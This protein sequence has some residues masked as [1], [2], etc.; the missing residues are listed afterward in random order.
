MIEYKYKTVDGFNLSVCNF[1]KENPKGVVQIV[2]GLKEH[3]RRY[4]RF[5]EYLNSKGYG[6]FLSDNRGHGYSVDKNNPLGF[7]SGIDQL[8]SDQ[9]EINCHIKEQY[10]RVP[11]YML[12]HS[13][14]S[15]IARKYIQKNDETINGLILSGTVGFNSG[16]YFGLIISRLMNLLL[17]RKNYSRILWQI[18]DNGDVSWVCGN[19]EIMAEY[20]SDPF[21]IG[22]KYRNN[23]VHT[24][25]EAMRELHNIKSYDCKNPVLPILS[26]AGEKDPVTRFDAGIKDSML[27]LKKAGYMNIKSIVYE[28]MLHE[29]LN[30]KE[31]IKV[32]EDVIKFLEGI[33]YKNN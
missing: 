25:M 22:Y 13:F 1:F 2:H 17:G 11:V 5:A 9:Y 31:N 32:Y 20:N 23:A 21:C 3:K 8:V 15:M 7:M 30:E 24:I 19:E 4:Y 27:S 14:G 28:N 16:V 29:V 18:V 33:D 26:I 6:V 12:G 10:G